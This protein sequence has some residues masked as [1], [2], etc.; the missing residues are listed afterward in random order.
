MTVTN[1]LRAAAL[2]VALAITGIPASAEIAPR[3]G[4]VVTPSPHDYATLV[5]RVD[6][7][8]AANKIGVVTRASATVGAK[9]VLGKT[10]P[11]NMVIGLYHPRFAVP[12]L[13]ASVAAGIEAPIRVY[14]TENADGTATLSYK[15]PSAVFAPYMGEGG[16]ALKALATELDAVFAAVAAQATAK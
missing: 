11:G 8:A 16:D 1:A 12:M 5:K 13:E 6:E 2:A 9:T 10:L 3:D 15:T 7:A 14:V 4:W